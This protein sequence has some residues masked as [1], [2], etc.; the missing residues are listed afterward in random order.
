MT[1]GRRAFI[2]GVGFLGSAS[3]QL[4]SAASVSEPSPKPPIAGSTGIQG[5]AYQVDGWD[6]YDEAAPDGPVISSADP[7][8]NSTPD[9]QVW[10]R[11][12]R[13]WRTAWR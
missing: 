2:G 10:I 11:I 6:R 1:I 7:T 3:I 4:S 5:V 12:N 8:H 9:L 13:S